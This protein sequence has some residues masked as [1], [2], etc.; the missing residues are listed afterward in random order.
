MPTNIEKPQ[1]ATAGKFIE[2]KLVADQASVHANTTDSNLL[3]PW[4]LAFSPSGPFWV[5]NNTSGTATVYGSTGN[6]D[7]IVVGIPTATGG[8]KGPVSGQVYNGTRNFAVNGNV[9]SFIFCSEDGIITAWTGS[10]IAI[11]VADR[12]ATGAVYKGLA[13]GAYNGN[14]YLYV[15]NF[16]SGMIDIFNSDY[17]YVTSVTDKTLPAGYGPFGIQNINNRL[18]VTFAKQLGPANHDNQPGAGLGYIDWFNTHGS[19]IAR[20]VS[21]GAL[22]SPW[23]IALAPANFGNVGGDLLIGNFGDGKINAYNPVSRHFDGALL[24]TTGTP[25]VIPGLWALEPGNGGAGGSASDVYFTSG[26]GN[27]AHGLFGGLSNSG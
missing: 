17:K 6:N 11:K 1:S 23:G 19:L 21:N 25:L 12:S 13:I 4:G 24:G 18:Y 15:T 20:M 14:N 2:T 8:T 3:N 10:S 5:A 26:P 7:G 16:H 22:N 27:E 9:P